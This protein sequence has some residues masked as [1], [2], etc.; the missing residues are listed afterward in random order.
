MH[1]YYDIAC[2]GKNVITTNS[3]TLCDFYS[4]IMYL[5]ELASIVNMNDF[6]PKMVHVT[7]VSSLL[8]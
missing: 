4:S 6:V 1:M 5:S 8:F 2:Q 3:Y 7:F